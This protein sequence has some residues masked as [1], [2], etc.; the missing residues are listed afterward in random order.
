MLVKIAYK[1][2]HNNVTICSLPLLTPHNKASN[3]QNTFLI[4]YWFMK[5]DGL[6]RVQVLRAKLSHL[7]RKEEENKSTYLINFFHLVYLIIQ[8]K[9][10]ENFLFISRTKKFF[11]F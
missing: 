6:E 11:K 7:F 10:L 2:F 4:Y 1:I 8:V 5:I 3:E 9:A